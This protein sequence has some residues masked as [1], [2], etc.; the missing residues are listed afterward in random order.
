[1]RAAEWLQVATLIVAVLVVTRVLG[2]YLAK[3]YGGGAAPGDR[4]FGPV[5]R[6]IYKVEGKVLTFCFNAAE[7]PK[8][9]A[10]KPDSGN[11]LMVFERP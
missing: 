3:V 8:G 1:M 5:E 4:L 10:S 6:F 11:I 2:A 9:F 7:R